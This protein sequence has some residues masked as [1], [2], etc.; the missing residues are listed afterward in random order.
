MRDIHNLDYQ[1]RELIL[2]FMNFVDP[3]L[4]VYIFNLL[5]AVGA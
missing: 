3:N 4:P 2:I 5:D 1:Q